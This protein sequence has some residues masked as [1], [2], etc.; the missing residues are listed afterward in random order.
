MIP[1]AKDIDLTEAYEFKSIHSGH[2]RP[3]EAGS[4]DRYYGRP[5]VPNFDYEGHRYHKGDMTPEQIAEYIEGWENEIDRKDWG[6]EPIES[7]DDND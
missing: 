7:E 5:C 4:A 6:F 3:C 2:R 1:L